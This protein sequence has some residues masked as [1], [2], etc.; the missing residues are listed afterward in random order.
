MGGLLAAEWLKLRSV[1]S[2]YW[3]GLAVLVVVALLGAFIVYA[4]NLWDGLPAARRATLRVANIE[5]QVLMPLQICGAVLGVLSVTAEHTTR[6][7]LTS[8][9]AAPARGRFLAAKAL[10]VGATALV[11]AEI[12]TLGTYLLARLVVGD[13]TMRDYL[14]PA[15]EVVPGLA[16]GA[17]SVLVVTLIGFALAVLL[18]STPAAI[19]GV[20]VLVFVLPR[21]ATALPDPWNIRVF[22]VLPEHLSLFLAGRPP[23][24]GVLF[25]GAQPGFALTMPLAFGLLAAYAVVPLAAAVVAFRRRDP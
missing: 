14:T 13:R 2:T 22:M 12:V 11:A 23:G 17:V 21:L 9:T 24:L 7:I 15:A 6:M 4:A 18:R 1:R 25:G 20:V 3:I 19:I 16:L 8:L 10:V 5:H